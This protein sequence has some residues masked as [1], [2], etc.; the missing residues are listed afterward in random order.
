MTRY[1]AHVYSISDLI[2]LHDS[3]RLEIQPSFQR[4]AVWPRQA[5]PYLMDTIIRGI[6][7]PKIYLRDLRDPMAGKSVFQV[8]DGQQRMGSIFRFVADE[9]PL[10]RGETAVYAGLKFS[11][12]PVDAHRS[13]LEYGVAAEII[14]NADDDEV[15]RLFWRLNRYTV[16]INSQETRHAR[17]IGSF[18]NAVYR[19]SETHIDSLKS[20]LV[21]SEN[22]YNRMR[23]AEF[24][25]DILVALVDGISDIAV[26]DQKYEEYEES[27]P[28]EERATQ[29]F[30]RAFQYIN[31]EFREAITETRFKNKAWFYSLM[32]ALADALEGIPSGNGVKPILSS[33]RIETRMRALDEELRDPE[34]GDRLFVL[35]QSLGRGTSHVRERRAR[36]RSFY[37]LLTE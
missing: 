28:A 1:R 31:D 7:M 33:E 15:W 12:L 6:P 13:F 34:V 18:K 11:Q 8:V 4:R 26:L 30:T 19:L 2:R 36:H 23:E 24:I 5:A 3:E 37:S 22:Q 27:F 10:T 21:I 35:N 9:Y 14:E 32:V 20:L 17:F 25:S 16:K 29:L